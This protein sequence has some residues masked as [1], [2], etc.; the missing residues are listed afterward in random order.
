MACGPR[1]GP[2]A[3]GLRV[4]ATA[5]QRGSL[6]V[7]WCDVAATALA[8]GGCPSEGSFADR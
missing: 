5:F 3:S 6:M 1:T 2:A 8:G 7:P 4:M